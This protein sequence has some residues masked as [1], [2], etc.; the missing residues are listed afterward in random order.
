MNSSEGSSDASSDW[1]FHSLH[2]IPRS[3]WVPL[4]YDDVFHGQIRFLV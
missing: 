4:D 3:V 2:R 1:L